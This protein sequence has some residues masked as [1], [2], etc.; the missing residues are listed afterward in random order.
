M[1]K[2]LVF[3][4]IIVLVVLIAV[5]LVGGIPATGQ[6]TAGSGSGTTG[7]PTAIRKAVVGRGDIQLTVSATGNVVPIRQSN[8]AFGQSGL[9]TAVLV[10]QD[11]A[12]QAGQ[13][14]ARVDN[15]AQTANLAQAENNLKAAQATLQKLLEPVDPGE[16]AKAEANVKAAEA[17]YSAQANGT[18]L[19]QINGLKLQYQKAAQAAQ[20]AEKLRIQAGGQTGGPGDPNYDKYVAQLGQAQANAAIAQLNLQKAAAGTS[21]TQATANIAYQQALLAQLKAGPKQSDIDAAQA[22]EVVAKL[23]RDQAQHQ[24]DQT[25]LVA[26]YAGIVSTVNAKPGM[27][28][29]GVAMVISDISTLYVDTTVD[30]TDIG[31]IQVGQPV[32]ITLNA[33]PNV[34]LT[35]KVTRITQT[36]DTTASVIT[37]AVRIALD[38]TDAPIKVGMSANA[39]FIVSQA[40][41]VLRVPNNYLRVNNTTGQT[42]VFL[43]NAD[44]TLLQVPVTTGLQGSDYTEIV[45]GLYEGETMALITNTTGGNAASGGN[46]GNANA[47][48]NANGNNTIGG[49]NAGAGGNQVSG[50]NGG[51]TNGGGNPN[52]G[53]NGNPNANAAGG[54]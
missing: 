42:T 43:V 29:S 45:N 11:Q 52:A 48:G 18:T 46:S 12:V 54:N 7:V 6:G 26:P 19:A 30:E 23:Q 25:N 34:S 49:G 37:Y 4:G 41:N 13:V 27:T 47:G 20:D 5:P 16:I 40:Q 50:G 36:A 44:G 32:Q 31:K 51:N 3:V 38:K 8:L 15:S 14:L 28:S 2:V 21:L 9:V 17:S 10:E 24:L 22:A 35:G 39:I 1:R 33:L 53:A